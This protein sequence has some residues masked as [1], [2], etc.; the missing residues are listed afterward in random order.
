[1][2]IK[3]H[4]FQG[5]LQGSATILDTAHVLLQEQKRNE[6]VSQVESSRKQLLE[7]Q[8]LRAAD[9]QDAAE[10]IRLVGVPGSSAFLC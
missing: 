1:M 7:E 3:R 6:A 8:Q 4:C 2:Y 9:Q 10:K 5:A